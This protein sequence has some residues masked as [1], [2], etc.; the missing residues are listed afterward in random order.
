M[1][2][3]LER[4]RIHASDRQQRAEVE[5]ALRVGS[6][7][8]EIAAQQRLHQR[9]VI[10]RE[11]L[12]AARLVVV[13]V[14]DDEGIV[15]IDDGRN[16]AAVREEIVRG[17]ALHDRDVR[18]GACSAASVSGVIAS[19][20]QP[21]TAPASR[22]SSV[23]SWPSASSTFAISRNR[24]PMPAGWPMA[25]RLGADEQRTR[26][27]RPFTRSTIVCSFHVRDLKIA[28]SRFCIRATSACSAPFVRCSSTSAGSTSSQPSVV[29][30]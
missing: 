10:V 18:F 4:D 24:M 26:H 23:T 6:A 3:A 12:G 28:S 2:I 16:R 8:E 11:H 25:E 5:E 27:P 15:E 20:R 7:E 14:L 30:A 1:R 19:T 13:Q 22:E 29:A 9:R 21:S 17:V